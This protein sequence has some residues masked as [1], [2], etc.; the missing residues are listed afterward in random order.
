MTTIDEL[1]PWPKTEEQVT[2]DA[3]HRRL[4]LHAKVYE[5]CCFDGG[6]ESIA[7]LAGCFT[8]Y[9]QAAL[10]LGALIASDRAA[11]EDLARVFWRATDDGEIFSDLVSAAMDEAHLDPEL[12]IQAYL[13]LSA[14]PG[15]AIEERS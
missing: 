11:A 4:L 14:K 12:V 5:C 8:G 13:A 3:V 15:Q 7:L 9:S 2:A 10:L 1:A 6:D